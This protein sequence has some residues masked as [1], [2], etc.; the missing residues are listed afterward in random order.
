MEIDESAEGNHVI[1]ASGDV[2]GLVSGVRDDTLY[3]DPDPGLTDKIAAKLG[4]DDVGVKDYV[5]DEESISH[6]T[7]DEVHLQVV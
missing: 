1:T 7:D 6:V 3:V 5:L 4:W 2:I